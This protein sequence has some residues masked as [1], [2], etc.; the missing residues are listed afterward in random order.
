MHM[1]EVVNFVLV[2]GNLGLCTS[3][4]R[5]YTQHMYRLYEFHNAKE[6]HSVSETLSPTCILVVNVLF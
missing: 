6:H 1:S 3:A 2:L 5:A 4:Y